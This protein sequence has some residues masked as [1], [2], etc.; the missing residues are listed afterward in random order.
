MF[1]TFVTLTFLFFLPF[2]NG[3]FAAEKHHVRSNSVHRS[4]WSPYR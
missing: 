1:I 3:E 2:S 4:L